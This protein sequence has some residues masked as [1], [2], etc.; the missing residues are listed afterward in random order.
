MITQ[1]V[2]ETLKRT[3]LYPLIRVVRQVQASRQHV[4]P[5]QEL[6]RWEKL[7][8]PAPPP[9]IVKQRIVKDYAQN[10]SLR[11]LVETGTYLGEMIEAT[12]D[13]FTHIVSIELD[14]RWRSEQ[15][16]CS[17]PTLI[18]TLFMEIAVRSYRLFSA[19]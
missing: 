6:R 14:T 10:F 13:C 16:L 12:Q 9:R 11:T 19:S 1:R 18:S 5:E 2:K 3:P 15:H 4:T 8:R 17:H 7:G